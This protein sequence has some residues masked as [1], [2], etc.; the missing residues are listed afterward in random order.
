MRIKNMQQITGHGNIT[1]R[2][3]VAKILG[4]GLDM[5]DSYIGTK[6]LVR[7]EGSRLIFEGRQFELDGD[8]R[9][10]T[11]IYELNEY[12]RV[13]VVG[14]AKGI[15]RC[16]VALEEILGKYL[17]GGHVIAKH[18]ESITCQVI[19]V[20]L[21]GHPVPDRYCRLGC[22]RIYEW[23]K[24][25]DERDLV[26]TITGSGVSSLMTWPV[27]GVSIDDIQQIT[28]MMQIERGAL[29]R[30]LN[31]IRVHLDRFKGGKILRYLR[32]ATIVNL[33]TNDLGGRL[34]A[35][36]LRDTYA[37]LM[38]RNCFIPTIADCSS[39]EDAISALKKYDVWDTIPRNIRDYLSR[40]DSSMETVKVPEYEALN[41]RLFKLTPKFQLVYPAIRKKAQE[42]GYHSYMLAETVAAEA[43]EVGKVMANIAL[44]VQNMNEPVKAPCVLL[45]SGELVVTV[46]LEAG[47]GGPNQ[48]FCVAAAQLIA[49]SPR[50]VIGAV[51][52]DGTDGPGGLDIDGAPECLCGAIVDGYSVSEGKD[53]GL[54]FELAL[55]THGT[56]ELLWRLNSAIHASPSISVLDLRAI[57]IMA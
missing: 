5:A 16:A 3:H 27:E 12:R 28:R 4:A 17:T 38:S 1:G 47:I 21:A 52:T 36:G 41:T 46:E 19:G 24:D 2:T 43:A 51:D 32:R 11:A 33:V 15:Q 34:Y 49:G 53:L 55:R 35:P 13:V 6:Q 14:A 23:I 50:I 54:D 30:D 10:G 26:I 31:P 48:E 40:M 39:Y 29:T 8:P 9:S 22:Q 25:I 37:E 18:G 44:T 20:T 45:S 7:R 42:L 57:L 56:S